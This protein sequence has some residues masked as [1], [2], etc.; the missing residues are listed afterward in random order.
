MVEEEND[1]WEYEYL[2]FEEIVLKNE[3][4]EWI[5]YVDII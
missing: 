2:D 5:E 4:G 1:G 3:I